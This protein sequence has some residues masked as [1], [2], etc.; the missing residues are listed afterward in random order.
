MP[1]YAPPPD[2]RAS[3]VD[4]SCTLLPNSSEIIEDEEVPVEDSAYVGAIG[5]AS[6]P[7][8]WVSWTSGTRGARLGSYR[9]EAV[10]F[11]LTH[12]ADMYYT[13][14]PH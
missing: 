13:G 4:I 9:V 3:T 5:L 12:I 2:A 10:A 11:N 14:V 8:V 1:S 7:L 6:K